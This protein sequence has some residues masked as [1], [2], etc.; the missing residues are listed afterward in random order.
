MAG[1]TGGLIG[2]YI[3]AAEEGL[4]RRCAH[5][6]AYGA[7]HQW[8]LTACADGGRKRE[9]CDECDVLLR[10]NAMALRFL[11]IRGAKRSVETYANKKRAT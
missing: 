2:A 7:T 6:R 9:L 4:L 5:C 11:R 8:T 10:M 3:V 1:M